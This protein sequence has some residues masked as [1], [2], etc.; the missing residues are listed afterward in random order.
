[1]AAAWAKWAAAS[2]LA[3]SAGVADSAATVQNV[4]M[5]LGPLVLQWRSAGGIPLSVCG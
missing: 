5:L 2:A 1:M 4:M 3:L